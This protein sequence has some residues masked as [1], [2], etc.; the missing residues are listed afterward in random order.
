MW[1]WSGTKTPP[2]VRS[3]NEAAEEAQNLGVTPVRRDV[4]PVPIY[5]D[6]RAYRTLPPTAPAS[7]YPDPLEIPSPQSPYSAVPPTYQQQPSAVSRSYQRPV[8]P[9]QAPPGYPGTASPYPPQ[10]Y[11]FCAVSAP[12][13]LRSFTMWISGSV[14][15]GRLAGS[16]GQ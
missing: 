14:S 13:S 7:A 12:I 2:P 11:M 15:S 8:M 16:A 4:R 9:P 3:R 5:R 6:S 1:D 10:P